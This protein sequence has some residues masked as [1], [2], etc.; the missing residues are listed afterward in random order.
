LGLSGKT[1]NNYLKYRTYHSDDGGDEAIRVTDWNYG[2][3]REY[4]VR[5]LQIPNRSGSSEGTLVEV[6]RNE[7]LT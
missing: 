1:Y 6:A 4:S 2:S 5:N 7:N 3:I